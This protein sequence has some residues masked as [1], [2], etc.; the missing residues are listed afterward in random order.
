MIVDQKAKALPFQDTRFPIVIPAGSIV[1]PIKVELAHSVVAQPGV[2]KI[3]QADT[4]EVAI[5]EFAVVV[6]AQ[7][8][9]KI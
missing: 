8:I 6:N 1:V 9:L 7:V 4:P 3:S 2:Q 5:I